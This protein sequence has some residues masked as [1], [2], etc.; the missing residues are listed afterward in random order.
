MGV[1]SLRERPSW[2][3][4][5]LTKRSAAWLTAVLALA[6][7]LTTLQLDINGSSHP[8][9]TDVGEIQNALPRW[10]TIHFTGYPQF[11]ALGSL[12][13]TVISWTGVQPA[14]AASLYAAVWG[15]VAM[16]AL[17]YLLMAF[18][19]RGETAVV[20]ALL[21][22]LSTSF[23]VD[24]SI[25]EIHTMTMALT[26]LCL[27]YAVYFGRNGRRADLYWLAFWTGQAVAHQRAIAFIGLGLLILVIRHWRMALRHL[28]AIVGLGSIGLLTYIYLPLRVWMGAQWT[29]NNPGTWQGFWSIFFDTKADRIVTMPASLAEL[30]QRLHEVVKLLA[31][32]WPW[33]LLVLGLLGLLLAGKA[34]KTERLAL[35]VGWLSYLAV[36]SIIWIG[37]VGE[38]ILA[39]KL[40]IVA[41]AAVGLAFIIHSLWEWRAKAGAVALLA[42]VAVGGWLFVRH[43]PAVLAVTRD[44]GANEIIARV[45]QVP[46]A[47][48]GR[49]ITFMA[50]EGND[51]WQLAYAQA[52]HDQFPHLEIVNHYRDFARIL[53][54]GRH[55]YTLS[56]TFFLMPVSEWEARLDSPIY[57]S[58]VAPR[59][60]EIKT[61]PRVLAETAESAFD[62][63]NGMQ[64]RQVNLSWRDPELLVL[65][66]SWQ[67]L[68]DDLPD[69][70]IAVHLVSNDPPSGPQD[71][72]AQSDRKHPVN[73]R[74]P[75]SRWRAGE[76]VTGY[77]RLAVPEDS[78]P[79]AVRVA[80]YQ[81]DEAGQF[82]NTPWLSIPV[83]PH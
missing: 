62:L 81:V 57:L 9:V 15:A 79:V 42:G 61:A 18:E 68:M 52:Y 40:P 80:M 7:F 83:P 25:A 32:D 72:I 55:L 2:L 34:S 39:V 10:G 38:A 30:G 46:E 50:L 33:P 26:F 43:Q 27:L 22:A 53:A 8:Y 17:V 73:G 67:A 82:V 37:R 66:V 71:I 12:F 21:F 41:L 44:P 45:A 69:Y 6:I 78:A 14:L 56:Q 64:I 19:V 16:A 4:Y 23:W 63:Q 35:T 3:A 74:Y 29:F 51:Y 1:L 77:Y 36:S 28:P 48:D 58:A 49:P 11:T 31:D 70:S 54:E 24:A 13:V 76:V 65:R 60:V 20:T 59:V 47:A 75:T 5:P